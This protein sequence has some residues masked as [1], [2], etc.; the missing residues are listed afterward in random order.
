MVPD[1][2]L[3]RF[4]TKKYRSGN[5]LKRLLIRRFAGKLSELFVDANPVKSVLE[6][7]IGEGFLSGYLSERFPE[8]DFSGVDVSSS[9]LDLLK[10]KFPRIQT[11]V[12]SIYALPFSEGAFDLIICAEVLEHLERPLEALEE[13]ARLRP[14]HAIFSVPHEPWF[15]LSNL[16]AG[17][18]VMRL[19]NDP[20]HIQHYGK[21]SF[22]RLL[23][24]C[25]EVT[26]LTSAYP[27]LLAVVTPR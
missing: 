11:H 9:D 21:R 12:G 19:G 22:R 27:W 2:Y 16:A 20:E 17:S 5:P 7:G 6:V 24:S 23:S 8:V 1:S 13:V 26:E 3:D 14:R 15:M 10:R 4:S 25:F 18:N